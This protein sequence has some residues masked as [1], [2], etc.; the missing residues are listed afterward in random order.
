MNLLGCRHKARRL[1][2][3]IHILFLT[4]LLASTIGIGQYTAIPTAVGQT[5]Q[6]ISEQK[7]SNGRARLASSRI[8]SSRN[9]GRPNVAS[10]QIEQ[11]NELVKKTWDDYE[12]KPSPAASDN[13]WCRRVFLDL[14]GRIPTIDE[15][16]AF[17]KDKSKTKRAEL[18]D[19]LMNDDIYIE[20]FARNWTTIW[21][22]ILIGRTG[23]NDRNSMISRAGMQKYLRDS[24]ARAKP[25]NRMVY[26]L[27]TA[28]GT[29]APS[30]EKFNGAVNF[31]IDKVND[32]NAAQATAKTSQI[33]LGLQVQC[34][35]CH[36][37][38]FNDWKQQ[39]YWEMNAFFRQSRTL[40]VGD[41]EMGRL[42]E[43][44]NQ[45]YA[46]E[47]RNP[48]EADLFYELRNGLVKVAYPVFVNGKS[49]PKSGYLNDVNRR[50]ELGKM[51]L[52]SPFLDKAIV[53]RMWSHF[54]GYGFTK[55]IDDL[56]PHNPPSHPELMNYLA[57]EFKS[58][59]Y[60]MRE[61]ITWIVLSDAYG[62][63]SRRTKNNQN[64][65]PE[66]GESPKFSHFYL[67]QM[68][69]E[70]LYESLV[71][72]TQADQS[73]GNYEAQE[74]Q[75]NRWLQQFSQAFGN[76]EGDETTSFNGT[77]P[78][79]LMMFN[80]DLIKNATASGKG[81]L[82]ERVASNS[83]LRLPKKV[84]QL[85]LAGLSRRATSSE[86]R[87]ATSLVR[88]RNGNVKEGLRDLW[89]VIL[90]SNEFIFNH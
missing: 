13:E 54:L 31:L 1:S 55:P 53:N 87:L 63:S 75:K 90:N 34:T 14:I 29:P 48:E 72:A 62:L 7:S 52:E 60:D 37:H 2:K 50:E 73:A 35:Q 84:D 21:T 41:S 51:I 6:Q 68:R 47:S 69:A 9:H 11:I 66:L 76:D 70:E 59:Q 85:F 27:V 67:R 82:L 71:V 3:T 16:E 38:P 24:F 79:V 74:R 44:I 39:K 88:A 65:D 43:L 28:T 77:I 57:D 45:D 19:R 17:V 26:E 80:G 33:F 12:L 25:Y 5:N 36:N 46:G 42:G 30:S 20:E 64:D 18:V 40:R 86:Q 78:Q 22:N 15:V 32:E 4:V 89:W 8:T 10:I 23:G 83:K 81:T 58:Y 49:I 61:L 56:G